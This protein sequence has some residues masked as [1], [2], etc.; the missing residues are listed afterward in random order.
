MTFI[1]L[2]TQNISGTVLYMTID[3]LKAIEYI[4]MTTPTRA[5]FIFRQP[6]LSYVA[7]VFTLPFTREVWISSFGLVIL[8]ACLLY[9]TGTYFNIL[10]IQH[11]V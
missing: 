1:K 11:Q 3:R 10:F 6:P 4:A 7:N 2:L 9:I 5:K 8:A